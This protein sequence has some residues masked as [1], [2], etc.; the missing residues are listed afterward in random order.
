V[1]ELGEAHASGA[2]PGEVLLYLG[3]KYFTVFHKQVLHISIVL[4]VSFRTLAS[5]A[6]KP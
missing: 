1:D 2:V 4:G 6:S 5:S 3:L